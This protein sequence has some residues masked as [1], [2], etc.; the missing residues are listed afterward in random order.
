MRTDV[1]IKTTPRALALGKDLAVGAVFEG[2]LIHR[3]GEPPRPHWHMRVDY[4]AV[5]ADSFW[6]VDIV[7]G[8]HQKFTTSTSYKVAS[9][10]TINVEE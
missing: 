10:V 3:V 2:G 6:A 9:R 8:K 1:I 4:T 5:D 7:T